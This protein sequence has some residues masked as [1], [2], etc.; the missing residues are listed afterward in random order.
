MEKQVILEEEDETIT[1]VLNRPEKLNAITS[2]MKLQLRSA[3]TEVEQSGRVAFVLT[4]AG[5]AFC[6]GAD[7]A[8]QHRRRMSTEVRFVDRLERLESTQELV[9]RIRNSHLGSIAAVNGVAAGGGISLALACDVVI[10]AEG[11]RFVWAFPDR[12]LVPDGELTTALIDALGS[13]RSLSLL[14]RQ[15][16]FTA[17]EALDIGLVDE[18]VHLDRLPDRVRDISR[19][20]QRLGPDT[21]ALTKRALANQYAARSALEALA[22]SIGLSKPSP[23]SPA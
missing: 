12:G 21:V 19:R 15:D 8:G 11:A 16:E 5:R 4:G 7:L 20:M 6:A 23:T 14:L 13:R 1:V 22:Q 10:A 17:P 2:E 3:L 18:V 9:R